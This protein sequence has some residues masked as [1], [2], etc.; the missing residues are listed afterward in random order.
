MG[1]LKDVLPTEWPAKPKIVLPNTHAPAMRGLPSGTAA[2]VVGKEQQ[3]LLMLRSGW[4]Q[5]CSL[6][7]SDVGCANNEQTFFFSPDGV[8]ST[9]PDNTL[10]LIIN[11]D[12][13]ANLHKA[14]HLA[15]NVFTPINSN[16]CPGIFSHGKINVVWSSTSQ[17]AV[18]WCGI[19]ALYISPCGS[20]Y[21][22][23]H[24][25]TRALAICAPTS[26]SPPDTLICIA[27]D[28]S[29]VF[30]VSI[31]DSTEQHHVIGVINAAVGVVSHGPLVC[32]RTINQ[33]VLI[34][35]NI[36]KHIQQR[37]LTLMQTSE[38]GH[39]HFYTLGVSQAARVYHAIAD[40]CI[41]PSG[42]IVCVPQEM[43]LLFIPLNDMGEPQEQCNRPCL[44]THLPC[45][46]QWSPDGSHLAFLN[47]NSLRQNSQ[48]SENKLLPPPWCVVTVEL[49]H[50]GYG[51]RFKKTCHYID[52]MIDPDDMS[53]DN[54]HSASRIIWAGPNIVMTTPSVVRSWP[55]CKA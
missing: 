24:M 34:I 37:Q 51:L 28:G 11:M 5:R 14:A 25:P 17:A 26:K 13:T 42:K 15:K 44:P 46:L 48:D 23:L 22:K 8:A 27:Q 55:I 45:A 50:S 2:A 49:E 31:T 32:L 43:Y 54:L 10:V 38:R 18:V 3:Q 29:K 47:T 12:G 39:N 7:E 53:I 30:I 9:S 33:D 21:V 19:N 1:D 16:H 20:L 41:H 4:L 40:P 6:E 52:T 36:Y 35:S